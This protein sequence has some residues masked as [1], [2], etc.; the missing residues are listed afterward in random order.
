MKQDSTLIAVIEMSLLC[1]NARH[2]LALFV[3]AAVLAN[4][5]MIVA[6]LLTKR[7][8]RLRKAAR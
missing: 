6:A 5:L 2:F 8:S 3:G 7:S 4:N 1:E